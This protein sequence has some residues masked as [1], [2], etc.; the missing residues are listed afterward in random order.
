MAERVAG[1]RL[2][3]SRGGFLSAD[4]NPG[5]VSRDEPNGAVDSGRVVMGRLEL[6]A[7]ERR[8]DALREALE[9]AS[10]LLAQDGYDTDPDYR[11]EWQTIT[12]ALGE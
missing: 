5:R 8:L 2:D 11:Q 6:E 7:L 4:G 9:V 12:E 10:D 1:A 3:L